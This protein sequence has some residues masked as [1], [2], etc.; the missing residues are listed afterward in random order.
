MQYG[1][2]LNGGFSFSLEGNTEEEKIKILEDM[3]KD[4][5]VAFIEQDE[6]LSLEETTTLWGL[7]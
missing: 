5:D 7:D 2:V 3:E 1:K 4:K 6:V